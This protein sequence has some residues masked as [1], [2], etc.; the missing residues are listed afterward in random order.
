MGKRNLAKT[1][2]KFPHRTRLNRDLSNGNRLGS[3]EDG[4][5]RNLHI[6]A[7]I[8]RSW[9]LGEFVCEWDTREPFWT[10]WRFRVV[11]R[12]L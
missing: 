4:G 8:V 6:T 3:L 1:Y 5:I 11:G 9:G 7:G 10:H 2:V 12:R